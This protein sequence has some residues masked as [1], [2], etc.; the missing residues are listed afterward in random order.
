[1]L[2]ARIEELQNQINAKA[3]QAVD[4]GAQSE[5]RAQRITE[6]ENKLKEAEQKRLSRE[7]E[8]EILRYVNFDLKEH[9]ENIRQLQKKRTSCVK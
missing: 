2:S 6:L 1:M 5:A 7:K 9:E 3:Q 8:F 4:A